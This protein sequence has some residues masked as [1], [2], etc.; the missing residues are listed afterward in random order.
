MKDN[1]A[2]I[3]ALL[4][5]LPLPAQEEP[6]ATSDAETL[7]AIRAKALALA[8]FAL[9]AAAPRKARRPRRPL[10]VLLAALLSFGLV[11]TALA[12]T[13]IGFFLEERFGDDFAFLTKLRLVT[14][15]SR[16]PLATASAGDVTI[17]LEAAYA[18]EASALLL[19]S[20]TD[21]QGRLTDA[22]RITGHFE[23]GGF[24]SHASTT[25]IKRDDETGVVYAL[26]NFISSDALQGRRTVYTVESIATHDAY[27]E[28]VPTGLEIAPL[29]RM[30]EKAPEI[31][32]Q[33][34]VRLK[35]EGPLAIPVDALPGLTLTDAY[36]TDEGLVVEASYVPAADDVRRDSVHLS[37][38]SPEGERVD[39]DYGS[40][41]F[42]AGDGDP[43]NE[44]IQAG[45]AGYTDPAALAGYTLALTYAETGEYIEGDWPLAFTMPR[46]AA[47]RTVY[48]DQAVTTG[49]LTVQMDRAVVLEN[50]VVVYAKRLSPRQQPAA[51]ASFFAGF[52]AGDEVSLLLYRGDEVLQGMGYGS[53]SSV[54]GEEDAA[55]I[56]THDGDLA[57][58]DLCAV[59][60]RTGAV[61][62][63]IPIDA[64]PN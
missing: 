62:L 45:F 26:I 28:G 12:T 15:Q 40:N 54:D 61:L 48:I 22:M 7:A 41:A 63:R 19:L 42:L 49:A 21:A 20:L 52:T 59:D 33:G 17:T 11:L 64:P 3:S 24:G 53:I 34:M 2:R 60:A 31:D 47:S 50:A 57:G 32:A 30:A 23:K 55:A 35:T 4:E 9:E 43:E 6:A 38:L 14:A 44:Y 25:A 16:G 51:D 1:P 36:V 37:L 5:G 46:D 29:I 13:D 56:L 39:F 8:G 10:R 18:N 58:V 27:V